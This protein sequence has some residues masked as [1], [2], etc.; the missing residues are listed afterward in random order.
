M[1]ETSR[2]V[3]KILIVDD[4]KENLIAMEAILTGMDVIIMTA[5][6]GEEALRLMLKEDFALVLLDVQMPGMDGFETAELMG[7]Y[8]KTRNIPIIFLT[9]LSKEDKYIEKGYKSG[10]VDYILKPANPDILRHK[11]L[12]FKKLHEQNIL[13]KTQAEKLKTANAELTE[14]YEIQNEALKANEALLVEQSKLATMGEMLGYMAHQWSQPINVLHLCFQLIHETINEKYNKDEELELSI[15]Q[16][17]SQIDY[18]AQTIDDFRNYVKPNNTLVLFNVNAA[19]MEVIKLIGSYVTKDGV[20]LRFACACGD[21]KEVEVSNNIVYECE[22]GSMECEEC[23]KD[24]ELLIKGAVNEFKQ[25]LI[26]LIHNAR[27]AIEM[28]GSNRELLKDNE[29]LIASKSAGGVVKV[30]VSDTAGGI[31]NDIQEKIFDA[32][33]TTKSNKGT[34]IGLSMVRSII[35][36]RFDGEISF[37]NNGK[38]AEFTL[39]FKQQTKPL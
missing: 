38:G 34:G 14:M 36:D 29:I 39:S 24:S 22:T 12:I 19:I 26:N 20:Q 1:T 21:S 2:I 6:N 9:A 13:I 17:L 3:T 5:L 4:R 31:P 18:M 10:A 37:K 8:E 23:E 30:V 16:G 33:F 35:N 7:G 32:Y 11:V 28:K 15:S 27:D 25:V